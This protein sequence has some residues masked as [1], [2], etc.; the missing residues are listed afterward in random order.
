M[1]LSSAIL[2]ANST[3]II[4]TVYPKNIRGSVLGINAMSVYLGYLLAPFIGGLLIRFYGWRSI[5]IVDLPIGI[6]GVLL[7]ILTLRN[8]EIKR[9]EN[10]FDVIGSILFPSGLILIV[11]YISIS[12][13]YNFISFIY[14]PVIGLI[15]LLIF[16]INEKK[17]TNPLIDLSLF[18]NNRTFAASNLSAFFNY[19]STFAIVF[20]FSVYLQTILKFSSFDSGLVLASEPLF[21]VAVSPIS[22]KLTD[23]YGSR[24]IAALGM[25]LIG[26]SFIILFLF[27]TTSMLSIIVPLSMIGIGFGL[28]SAPNTYS[29]I[30]S[31]SRDN[32][33][34]ASGILG[35][36]RS[37]GQLSSISLASFILASSL[38]R[39]LLLEMFSGYQISINIVYYNA[40]NN[41]FKSVMLVF[42][43]LSL[44]GAFISLLKTKKS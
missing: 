37:L 10:S 17:K 16:F 43:I 18:H 30:G 23:R 11:L 5:F 2:A 24:E 19:T 20:I 40:F 33:G 13:V 29:V 42:G 41:G 27:M 1:G 34:V 39:K 31:V 12:E 44:C 14:L 9:M 35:T 6:F 26:A 25:S 8:L 15:I 4:S 32:Y 28:F 3:A 7:S 22:G 36:M 21:M 38:P